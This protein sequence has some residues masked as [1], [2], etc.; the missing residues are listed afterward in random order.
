MTLLLLLPQGA[1]IH[2]ET[3]ATNE[4]VDVGSFMK[5]LHAICNVEVRRKQS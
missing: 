2:Q 1:R 4:I 5:D 3:S